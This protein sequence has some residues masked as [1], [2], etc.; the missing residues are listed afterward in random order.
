MKKYIVMTLLS[1]LVILISFVWRTKGKEASKDTG[2]NSDFSATEPQLKEK[3]SESNEEAG[4]VLVVYFSLTG[5][6]DKVAG[7]IKDMT[8]GDI[9]KIQPDFDYFQVKSRTEMEELG[10]KQVEEDYRPK[11]K[12]SVRN[13]DDY[14]YFIIGSPVWWFSVTPP[15][16]SFLSQYDFTDKTVIPFCTCGSAYGDFFEQF[17]DAVPG[18]KLLEEFSIT[19]PELQ[20]E[21]ERNKKIETWLTNINL[22]RQ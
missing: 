11:L 13:F 3:E 17:K 1:I 2:T 15:V 14:D 8:G 6:T 20:N 21:E 10:K 9:F 22:L 16:M 7:I 18:A 5:N 19:E 12:N 4:K